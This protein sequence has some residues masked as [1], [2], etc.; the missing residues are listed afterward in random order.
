[1]LS[2][3][4]KKLSENDEIDESIFPVD[5]PHTSNKPLRVVYPEMVEEKNLE[6]D[7][8]IIMIDFDGVIHKY[9][10]GFKD[11]T[12][13]D[14]P[15]KNVKGAIRAFRNKGFKV[16]IFTARLSE[17]YHDLD[18]VNNQ[19]EMIEEWLEKHGIE[20]DGM[21]TEKL[22]A[23][24]YIDDRGFRFSGDWNNEKVEKVIKLCALNLV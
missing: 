17:K 4:L 15:I 14:I 7:D 24:I 2:K 11:G 20:V 6:S 1:M 13:Y 23:L 5:S 16:I 19:K 12:I 10:E 3:Y 8:K 21:T 22:P 9:S 18:S